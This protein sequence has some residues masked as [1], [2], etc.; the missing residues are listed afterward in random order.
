MKKEI[1]ISILVFMIGGLITNA[2][3]LWRNHA[4]TQNR[5]SALEKTVEKQD[6]DNKDIV[7]KIDDIYW[8]LIES[9]NIKVPSKRNR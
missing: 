1:A 4:V 7:D 5:V 2:L 8:Y 6:N 9:K 3:A